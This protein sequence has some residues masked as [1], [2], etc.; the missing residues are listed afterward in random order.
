ML[1]CKDFNPFSH[2]N[3][4]SYVRVPKYDPN[5]Y[6]EYLVDSMF[7]PLFFNKNKFAITVAL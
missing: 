6:L 5:N 1:N 2:I 3:L 7:Q 4:S